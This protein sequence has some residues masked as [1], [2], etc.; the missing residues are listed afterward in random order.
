MIHN[1]RGFWEGFQHHGRAAESSEITGSLRLYQRG[2]VGSDVLNNPC[3]RV[4]L[5][6]ISE[7]RRDRM[8][9]VVASVRPQLC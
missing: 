8:I 1:N 3:F 9:H 2:S 7:G 4:A 6:Q 5:E